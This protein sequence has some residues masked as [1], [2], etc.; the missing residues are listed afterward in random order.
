MEDQRLV[1][2]LMEQ[3]PELE[4]LVIVLVYG[5]GDTEPQT[6]TQVAETLGFRRAEVSETKRAAVQR[7]RSVGSAHRQQVLASSSF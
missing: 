6:T 2:K 1:R 4:K 5:L 3:L 7:L